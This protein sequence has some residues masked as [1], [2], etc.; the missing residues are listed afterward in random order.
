VLVRFC[1]GNKF[2]LNEDYRDNKIQQELPNVVF[3]VDL[4]YLGIE[5]EPIKYTV[6]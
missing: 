4:P 6:D 1:K 3:P 2:I 5:V